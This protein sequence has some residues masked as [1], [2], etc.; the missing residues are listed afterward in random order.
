M[1]D[2]D[3]GSVSQRSAL[4]ACVVVDE[5]GHVHQFAIVSDVINLRNNV[6]TVVE[7]QYEGRVRKIDTFR[8]DTAVRP[9]TGEVFNIKLEGGQE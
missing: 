1:G 8:I 7:K 6:N 3:Y 4:Y 2:K 5:G 9:L